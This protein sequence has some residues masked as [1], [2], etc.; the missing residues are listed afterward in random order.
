MTFSLCANIGFL[1][2]LPGS[3]R[4]VPPLT[5]RIEGRYNNLSQLCQFQPLS[6]LAVR[7]KR[8]Y[9]DSFRGR[10]F[11]RAIRSQQ[12]LGSCSQ[13]ISNPHHDVQGNV[14]F[15]AFDRNDISARQSS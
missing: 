12:T 7:T 9:S 15:S 4:A 2:N 11:S 10:E 3:A 13:R 6:F 8:L 14:L 1:L 5:Q